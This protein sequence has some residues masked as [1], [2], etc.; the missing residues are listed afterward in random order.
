MEAI[1]LVM[2]LF[3]EIIHFRECCWW[4]KFKVLFL[5]NKLR[6]HHMSNCHASEQRLSYWDEFT[7]LPTT[8]NVHLTVHI[9]KA[10]TYLCFVG[11]YSIVHSTCHFWIFLLV[12]YTIAVSVHI[13][14]YLFVNAYVCLNYL[15]VLLYSKIC[16]LF[17][18]LMYL[19]ASLGNSGSLPT[20]LPDEVRKLK[21]LSVLPL[22]ESTKVQ[23]LTELV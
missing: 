21:Q 1:G 6:T 15:L 9:N 14:Y 20:L 10:W 12:W 8:M 17:C 23:I 22:V 7:F 5:V 2:D 19:Y 3:V 16:T 11:L 13:I 18:L 4:F